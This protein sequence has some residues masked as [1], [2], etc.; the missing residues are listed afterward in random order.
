MHL[1]PHLQWHWHF[2]C[3]NVDMRV[4][5]KYSAD[6]Q[7]EGKT[8]FSGLVSGSKGREETCLKSK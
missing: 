5:R 2:T 1:L 8:D 7:L 6:D 3:L 4:F